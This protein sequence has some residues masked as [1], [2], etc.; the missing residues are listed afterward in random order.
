MAAADCSFQIRIA[1]VVLSGLIAKDTA[2][3]ESADLDIVTFS[4]DFKHSTQRYNELLRWTDT[5]VK[6]IIVSTKWRTEV[7]HWQRKFRDYENS[8]SARI[9]IISKVS[10]SS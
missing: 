4:K 5:A 9:L 10:K 8:G 3:G 7:S 2:V 6:E 1:N